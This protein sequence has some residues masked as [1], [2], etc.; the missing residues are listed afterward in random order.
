[1]GLAGGFKP[2]LFEFQFNFDSGLGSI[3]SSS[4]AKV[5]L[6]KSTV[7]SSTSVGDSVTDC[8]RAARNISARA[9]LTSVE[10]FMLQFT[11]KEAL[12]T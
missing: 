3:K 7:S 11:P 6:T 4:N 10:Y 2:R 8:S 5:A 1:M 9:I 12:G